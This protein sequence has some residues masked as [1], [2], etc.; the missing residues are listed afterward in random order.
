MHS[1]HH[2]REHQVSHR[3]VHHILK[4]HPHGATHHATHGGGFSKV[5]SKTAAEE[6]NDHIVGRKGRH[7]IGG[8]VKARGGMTGKPSDIKKIRHDLAEHERKEHHYARGG[9]VGHKGKQGHQTNIVIASGHH[10]AA[11]PLAPAL[12]PGGPMAG[13]PPGGPGP[14]LPPG[15]PPGMPPRPGMPPPPGMRRGGKVLHGES[16]EGNIKQMAQRAAKHSYAR[17]GKITAG[18]ESGVGRLQKARHHRGK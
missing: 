8:C 17:G 5:T 11:S 9:K 3:R 16:T 15:G 12:P 18:A 4:G 7:R 2:H 6:H 13:P 14:M 10:P 1:H